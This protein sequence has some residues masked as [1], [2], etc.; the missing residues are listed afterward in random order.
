MVAQKFNV[1][2]CMSTL[3]YSFRKK[4]YNIL[5]DGGREIA[6]VNKF[7]ANWILFDRPRMY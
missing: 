7:E 2:A 4:W 3:H 6:L 1:H 5:G